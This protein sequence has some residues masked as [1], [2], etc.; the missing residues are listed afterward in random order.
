MAVLDR[1]QVNVAR[2]KL[3]E[4]ISWAMRS[5]LAPF[6][7]L[8]VTIRDHADG[9]LEYVRSGLT[10]GRTEALNGK[11][12]TITR[13]SYG[14]HSAWSLISSLSAHLRPISTLEIPQ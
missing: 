13:R 4:W 6:K 8:A 10:N 3:K 2:S 12:R 14:F 11:T 1:R 9:I 7:K 5:R